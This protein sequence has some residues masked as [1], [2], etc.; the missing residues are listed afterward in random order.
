ME[1]DNQSKINSEDISLNKDQF[2]SLLISSITS[3]VY[4]RVEE[5]QSKNRNIFIGVSSLVLAIFVS[6]GG[7]LMNQLM[8][9]AIDKKIA[10]AQEE[11]LGESLYVFEVAALDIEVRS[12]LE[13]DRF[14]NEDAE[15]IIRKID[16]LYKSGVLTQK[17]PNIINENIERLSYSVSKAILSFGQADRVDYILEVE[18]KASL[19]AQRSDEVPLV[20]AISLGDRLLQDSK[21]PESWESGGF[22]NDEYQKFFSYLKKAKEIGYPELYILYELFMSQSKGLS[23]SDFEPLLSDL[24][25]LSSED[26]EHF[27]RRFMSVINSNRNAGEVRQ[28]KIALEILRKYS[29]K[30]PTLSHLSDLALS[31]S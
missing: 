12:I 14:S 4:Q 26:I 22:L 15:S 16:R 24:S 17:D 6:L 10:Q 13:S 8:D 21:A 1:T 5:K 29:D 18:R 31:D 27:N 2:I 25:D 9:V 7:V 11:N 28:K 19:V 30:S 3:E 23:D 20:M